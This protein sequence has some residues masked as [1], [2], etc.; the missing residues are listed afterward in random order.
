MN[1]QAGR[2]KVPRS[3]QVGAPI[4]PVCLSAAVRQKGV[5]D[6]SRVDVPWNAL[7]FGLHDLHLFSQ[8][9]ICLGSYANQIGIRLPVAPNRDWNTAA[10]PAKAAREL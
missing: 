7:A 1:F 10:I 9:C 8:H 5:R 3:G 2:L 6:L 4:G